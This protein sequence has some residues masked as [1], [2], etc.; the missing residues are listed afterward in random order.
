MLD[1][2]QPL[3]RLR[4]RAALLKDVDLAINARQSFE[5][6]KRFPCAYLLPGDLTAAAPKQATQ[7]HMQQITEQFDVL[8][9][10]SATGVNVSSSKRAEQLTDPVRAITDEVESALIGWTWSPYVMP[11][12]LVR[13]ALVE[14][15]PQ[16]M[17]LS[18]TFATDFEFRKTTTD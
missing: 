4:D 5:D 1:L 12:R 6:I 9:F 17:V 11:L 18:R 15:T 10:V 7:V 2:L 8:I 16:R 3:Q 14:L 13:G